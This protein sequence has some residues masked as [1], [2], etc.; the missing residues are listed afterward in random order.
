MAHSV[1]CGMAKVKLSHTSTEQLLATHAVIGA[2]DTAETK[3]V[4]DLYATCEIE[5]LYIISQ[6]FIL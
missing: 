1:L 2:L 6:I 5:A 4:Y 3:H